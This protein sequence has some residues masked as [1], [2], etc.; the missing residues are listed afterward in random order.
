MDDG[1]ASF[2]FGDP[3]L[4][5]VGADDILSIK[6]FIIDIICGS[7]DIISGLDSIEE[8]RSPP[9]IWGSAPTGEA[10]TGGA[11]AV[12]FPCVLFPVDSIIFPSK[13]KRSGDGE[14][15]SRSA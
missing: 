2:D 5:D 15:F 7:F 1:I 8:S 10:F 4:A 12:S 13:E 14:F 3:I 11:L 6:G 9:D